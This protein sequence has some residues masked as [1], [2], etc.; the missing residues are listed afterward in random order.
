MGIEIERKFL[1]KN[2]GWR[3]VEGLL[4]RQGYL[5]SNRHRTVRVR[6]IGEKAFLTIKSKSVGATRSEY[7]Y[8]IPV[9]D[10]NAMLDELCEKPIIEKT[11][12]KV[13]FGGFTWEIDEFYGENEGL[14]LAEIELP[15]ADTDFALPPWIGEEVT[16]D[17][18]YFNANL[19]SNP[20]KNWRMD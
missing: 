13:E 15:T 19:V 10:A 4:Y 9:S 14:I 8:E 6:T 20:Y 16:E 18:R 7:E 1:L 3:Q 12:H 2:D 5:N 11:R 17:A